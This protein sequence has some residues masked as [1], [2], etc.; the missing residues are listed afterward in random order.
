V[1]VGPALERMLAAD[2]FAERE[3]G[4]VEAIEAL[5][6]RHNALG[7][8]VHLDPTVRN[9]HSRPLRVIDAGRF[10]TA[11]IESVSD[12]WLRALPRVGAID[13]LLDSTDVLS[14]GGVAHRVA[15]FYGSTT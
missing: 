2:D 8:T 1:E 10:A 9:F 7:L 3:S 11:C 13:Q 4:W 15:G 5:A 6:R 14:D 12:S